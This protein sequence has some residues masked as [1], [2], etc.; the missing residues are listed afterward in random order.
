MGKVADLQIQRHRLT[1]EHYH[2]LG[3]AGI[4]GDDARVELIEGELV[5]MTPIGSRHAGSVSALNDVFTVALHGRAIVAVQCPVML[6]EHS[7]PQPDLA[8][9][10]FRADYY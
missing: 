6:T 2:R 9:L 1:V 3:E 5:D 10:K 4:L 8:I 7:E